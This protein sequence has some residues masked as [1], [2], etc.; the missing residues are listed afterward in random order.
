MGINLSPE[1]EHF[2]NFRI[3]PFACKWWFLSILRFESLISTLQQGQI[4][5]RWIWWKQ[6]YLHSWLSSHL[7]ALNARNRPRKW[8]SCFEWKAQRFHASLVCVRELQMPAMVAVTVFDPACADSTEPN[9]QGV[10]GR[11]KPQHQPGLCWGARGNCAATL[12]TWPSRSGA[13]GDKMWR[14]PRRPSDFVQS[15]Q[16]LWSWDEYSISSVHTCMSEDGGSW[17][18]FWSLSSSCRVSQELQGLDQTPLYQNQQPDWQTVAGAWV[19]V[20]VI[21][22]WNWESSKRAFWVVKAGE[23]QKDHLLP[24]GQRCNVKQAE[25]KETRQFAKREWPRFKLWC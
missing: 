10:P 8:G 18:L 9:L 1:W 5:W 2:C 6:N 25:E 24:M 17:V 22:T 20:P 11:Q 15:W 4:A 21:G 3:G 23:T 12:Q 13:H 16:E 19:C 7:Q 14:P